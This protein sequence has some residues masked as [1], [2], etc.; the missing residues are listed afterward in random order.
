MIS[1]ALQMCEILKYLHDQEPPVVHRDFTPENLILGT[2]GTLRLID[3]NVAQTLDQA[4][5]TTGT[6]VGKPSY[7]APEQFRGEPMP[8]SDV[9]SMGATLGIYFDR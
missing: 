5:S 7:L 9:Y 6:V 2:D 8:S 3:F 1:L 4:A